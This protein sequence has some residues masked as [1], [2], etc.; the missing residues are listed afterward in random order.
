MDASNR[1]RRASE[2]AAT[3]WVRLRT[4]VLERADREEFVD[5]LRE[6]PVHV[7]E[8]LRVAKVHNTLGQFQGWLQVAI[9][10]NGD[11]RAADLETY[12]NVISFPFQPDAAPSPRAES[13]RSTRR[14]FWLGALAAGLAALA[15]VGALVSPF[16]QTIDTERGERRTVTLPDGSVVDVDPETRLRVAFE[17]HTRRVVLDK[18]RAL[19][20]VAKNPARPF[21]VEAG[22]TTVRAVGTAFGVERQQQ[23]IVVTVA[24]GKVEVLE[25]TSTAGEGATEPAKKARHRSE[26]LLTA[27][28]QVTMPASGEAKSVRTIESARE[29]SWAKGELIFDNET[30][31]AAVETFN[32]Y[33]RVQIRVTDQALAARPV[34]GVFD[35]ADPESF[36]GFLEVATSVRVTRSESEII[37]Q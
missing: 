37:L 10:D 3:W 9:P 35:A 7:A 29:L 28:Q 14:R 31:A 21:L 6:S 24:E 4:E 33:N 25:H 19:F 34:S 16:G 2:E 27:G 30:I 12:D 18:G 17:G 1:R 13:A 32:R 26:L 8:M 15:L 11:D 5:W 36:I 23:G 20:R 22:T